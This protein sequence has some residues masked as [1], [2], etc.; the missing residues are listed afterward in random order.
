MK[1]RC[2]CIKL[3]NLFNCHKVGS[4]IW[5]I[6]KRIMDEKTRWAKLN[7]RYDWRNEKNKWTHKSKSTAWCKLTFHNNMINLRHAYFN[8]VRIFV[9]HICYWIIVISHCTLNKWAWLVPLPKCWIC[10]FQGT[11]SFFPI[12]ILIVVLLVSSNAISISTTQGL[13]SIR[14]EGVSTNEM[15]EEE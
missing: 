11:A 4:Y 13:N 1:L 8:K 9:T 3:G 14:D 7:N 10:I 2:R 5:L 6:D 12:P 15:N